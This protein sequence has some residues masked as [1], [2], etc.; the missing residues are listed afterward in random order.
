MMNSFST[1]HSSLSDKNGPNPGQDPD[2][3]PCIRENGRFSINYRLMIH[4]EPKPVTL[5]AV[6]P[7]NGN[8][9]KLLIGVR[10]WKDRK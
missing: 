1:L 4:G 9:D 8:A 5:K 2:Y 6:L 3:H 7:K 10:A